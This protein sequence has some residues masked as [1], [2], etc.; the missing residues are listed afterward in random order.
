M[1]TKGLMR[2]LEL[3]LELVPGARVVSK[4]EEWGD[5]GAATPIEL[6]MEYVT[7]M[8]GTEI[9]E[10]EI[11]KILEDLEF[12][13][14]KLKVESKKKKTNKLS[15]FNSQLS[16]LNFVVTPPLHR[17]GD[18][19]GS[20]DLVE[21]IGRIKGY[22]SITPVLP[23]ASIEPPVRE[24]RVHILRDALKEE[25]FTELVPLSLIGPSLLQ[26]ANIDPSIAPEIRNP[27]GE[28]LSL[29]HPS[30]LPSLLSHAERNIS[31]AG[32]D[33]ATFH[34][35]KVFKKNAPERWELS[36]LLAP[37]HPASSSIQEE[38]L[39]RVK[40]SL[41][42][43]CGELGYDLACSEL[44][45]TPAYAHPG[46]AAEI[47]L[48]KKSE[49]DESSPQEVIGSL[50]E[51]HPDVQARFS[52]PHRAAVA[53]LD[54]SAVRALPTAVKVAK[55]VPLFPAVSYD[56]TITLSHREQAANML[57]QLEGSHPLLESVAVVDLYSGKPLKELEYNLTLRFT[58]RAADR[59]LTED[60]AQKA[61]EEVLKGV[62]G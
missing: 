44:R 61:Q 52:L 32:K 43:L 20:H 39:L 3:F 1:A 21:E 17:L 30:A 8:L 36:V 49:G 40:Q 42:Y 2:A 6:S 55:P 13:V 47:F 7:R 10:K 12:T 16:T 29:M 5:E 48:K 19:K 22:D 9:S 27:L 51:L 53:L 57:L 56:A 14:G 34:V 15:T 38:P 25:G 41:R 59:T 24:K 23:T 45:D 62:Q 35:G 50:F 58:Y 33:I 37:I 46:R 54:L 4:L 26:K 18:I 60:E 11:V 28:E 31:Y